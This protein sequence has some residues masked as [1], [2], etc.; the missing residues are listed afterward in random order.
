[1]Q[2]NLQN[3]KAPYSSIDY[4]SISFPA[5]ATQSSTMCNAELPTS[6]TVDRYLYVIEYYISQV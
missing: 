3:P 6:S 5:F 2:A 1:M 4:D